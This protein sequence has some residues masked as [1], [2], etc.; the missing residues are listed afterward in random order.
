DE[1]IR[2][3]FALHV[4]A[5]EFGLG[6]TDGFQFNI[7]VGYDLAGIQEQKINGFIDDMMEA[8][9]TEAFR[10][11]REWLLSNLDRF[12]NL[13]KEDVEAVPS[14]ICNSATISTLHG[15]PPQE[16]ESIARYLLTEKHL[17]TFVK[18]NPTLLG[19]EFARKTMD[20]MGYDYLVFGDF[21][22]RDD[23]QYRD[24]VP[25]LKRLMELADSLSLSFG[26]KITNTFPVDVTRNELPS[27][28]M[29]MSGKSLFPLSISLAAKL[30]REF[31]GKLRIAYSG[32]ADY[33]NMEKIVSCGIWPVTVATTLLK[34]GGYQR[35]LQI[36]EAL[37][38]MSGEWKG[39]DVE[40]LEALAKSAV[41]D[42]HHIKNI[43]PIPS[44]KSRNAVPLLDCFYAPCN[45]GCPIHQDI[46]EYIRLTG[47]GR[48]EEA[49]QVIL[50][51][52]PL[53][54][55]TGTLCAHNCMTKC[56]RNFYEEPVDIRGTKLAAAE[57]GY[58][59]VIAKTAP[60]KGSSLKV[61]VVGGGPAG[62][63][64]AY[65]L[66]REGVKVTIFEKEEKPGGVIRYVI[67]G[68]R[69]SQEA[70]DKDI[71]FL[72]KMGVEIR[73]GCE[74]SDFAQLRAQYGAVIV[75]IG[76]AKAGNLRLKEGTSVDALHF[77]R[78]F[79]EK[80]GDVALGKN[81]VVIGGGNTA[82]DTARAARRTR[83]VE[84][85]YLVYRRTRRY[86]PAEEHE[87][88][89]VLSE[90]VEFRELLAP[91]RLSDGQ[92]ICKK[93]VPGPMDAS[94]RA[95][96]TE[97]EEEVSI[98]A[99]T[100]LAA[101]GSKI[102]SGYY[103]ENGLAV[104]ERGYAV[105][106]PETLESVIPGIY[107]AGDGAGGAATI[108]EA[109]RDACLAAASILKKQLVQDHPVQVGQE[110]CYKKK[111][112][113]R[114][115]AMYENS[116]RAETGASCCSTDSADT[117]QGASCCEAA[118]SSAGAAGSS[119]CG[120]D[121]C[122]LSLLPPAD[123]TD[124]AVESERCLSCSRVCE[125]CV[126][127][128]PNRAN[129]SIRVPQMEN[130]QILHVD[131]M[132]NECGNCRSFCPYASAPYK[133][134]FTL[135]QSEEDM[136]DSTNEGFVVK[137]LEKKQCVVRFAGRTAICNADDEKDPLYPGLRRLILAVLTDYPYLLKQ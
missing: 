60:G 39:I 17:H 99:D 49:L 87:L 137:D 119:C 23:L 89:E 102:D 107:V 78:E 125:N 12:R 114:H 50:E 26:V 88:L 20:E 51:K 90:G 59:A 21:H 8:K 61:A 134:K 68:F 85:V 48:Y 15:C 44:R 93:M 70:I 64:A 42:P 77:L 11:C 36:A 122:S 109:I 55:I 66:A 74:I 4:L 84:H 127:V 128:C 79:K 113:L 35:F 106:N 95:S 3:W 25:M 131:Y 124:T 71:S 120:T 33:F 54:F 103:I 16:I 13:G 52:N 91:D 7:S 65:Y 75:A 58:D 46:P 81:V 118:G 130:P 72:E 129:I 82:M 41:R 115:S 45:E 18:C 83:G 47:E 126:D 31:D 101:V 108:V 116:A 135:F 92:L 9:D 133:D 53:P 19:Y 121:G 24:A 132:C 67:P 63:A 86:M 97:T 2:A 27:E 6:R 56:T 34:A 38:G 94:G 73:T 123:R 14:R 37:R 98:P 80:N 117:E 1:Y 30:S 112:I 136:K 10:E 110:E 76:A 32:G 40:A 100:V 105:L 62:I 22:F 29:Y 57:K 5:K 69:I 96:V 104:D 111:G 28:E 43:K